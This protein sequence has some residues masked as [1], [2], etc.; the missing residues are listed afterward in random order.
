M[1]MI[2]MSG[3][4]REGRDG[5]YIIRA[6]DTPVILIDRKHPET[7]QYLKAFGKSLL[8]KR[9]QI[10]VVDQ[11]ENFWIAQISHEELKRTGFAN[12]RGL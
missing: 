8:G 7:Q 1:T 4:L 12:V 2:S 3:I 11:M 5:G 6:P 9:V 10:T